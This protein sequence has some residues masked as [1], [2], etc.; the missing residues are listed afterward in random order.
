MTAPTTRK[1]LI[2]DDDSMARRAIERT[3][4]DPDYQIFSAS[5]PSEALAIL[6]KEDIRVVLSDHHMGRETGAAFLSVVETKYP[7]VVRI[8]MTSDTSTGVFI[9][10]VN[11][12]HARRVLYKPW[13]DEQLHAVVRQAFNLPRRRPQRA[14]VYEI[15]QPSS[16]TLTKIAAM[17][18]VDRVE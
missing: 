10:A 18:G 13:V 9:A 4:Q 15:K 16:R 7:H 6:E 3:L 17:L 14:P 5:S 1:L 11:E 8:L 2:V 12:G